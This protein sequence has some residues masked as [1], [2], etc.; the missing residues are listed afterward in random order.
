MVRFGSSSVLRM[1][2]FLPEGGI[3]GSVRAVTLLGA[4]QRL[5]VEVGYD[6]RLLVDLP[7]SNYPAHRPGERV[8]LSVNAE[9]ATMLSRDPLE[10]P[11]RD[12]V[13]R[14]WPNRRLEDL[15]TMRILRGAIIAALSSLVIG[16]FVVLA[17]WSVTK[18]WF[19]PSLLPTQLT[20]Y[21]F[22]WAIAVPGILHAVRMSLVTAVLTTLIVTAVALPAAFAVTR[23]QFAGRSVI[24]AL[25][26]TPMMVPYI[27]LGVGVVQLYYA[28]HL[29]DTLAGVVLAHTAVA[30]PVGIVVLTSAIAKLPRDLEEAAYI[31]GAS[32]ARVTRSI[33]VPTLL[34]VILAQ[35]IYVFTISIDEFTLTLLV[36]GPHTATLPIQIFSSIGDGFVQLTSALSLLLLVPSVVLIWVMIRHLS[37]STFTAAG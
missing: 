4:N 30:L 19:W 16:P 10:A 17:I 32:R 18:Q 23:G 26:A 3:P 37:S 5:E 29:I 21:W 1:S 31:C 2:E 14:R 12:T 28:W 27:A 7:A 36:S 8:G 22:E 9:R 11:P 25:F 15:L 34:P 6:L 13:Q 33:V 24:I 35:A 20:L